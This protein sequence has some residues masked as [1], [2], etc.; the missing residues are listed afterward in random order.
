MAPVSLRSA[1][2]ISRACRPTWLSPISPSISARGT[3]AA[4][5]SMTITSTALQRTSIS[6]ISSACS[7]VSGCDTSRLS[8]STPSLRAYSM[9]SACS[10]SMNAATP[11]D[12]LRVGDHVQT[13]RRLA[14]RLRAVDLRDAPARNAADADR[15]VQVDG[16]R[17]GSPRSATR[18]PLTP[19][20]MIEPLPKA[21]SIWPM[22]TFRAF[23]LSAAI[24][25]VAICRSSGKRLCGAR[26]GRAD[27][28][29]RAWRRFPKIKRKF[30]RNAPPSTRVSTSESADRRS[31]SLQQLGDGLRQA[32]PARAIPTSSTSRCVTARSRRA[33]NCVI[34]TPARL[35][36]GQQARQA[37]AVASAKSIITMFVSGAATAKPR[38]PRGPGRPAPA[39]GGGRAAAAAKW[40]RSPCSPAAARIPACRIPPPSRR[41]TRH[42]RCMASAL[43]AS[44]EPTGAPSPLESAIVTVSTG[45]AKSRHG[46]APSRRMRSAGARRPGARPRPARAPPA[47]T[48]CSCDRGITRPP[49]PLCVFSRHTSDVCGR[50]GDGGRT[51]SARCSGR[52][53]P[54]VVGTARS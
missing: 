39:R 17:S 3:S 7:P 23:F 41:R 28:T 54:S 29:P 37:P 8:T 6:A 10:A 44:M 18:G 4:T 12:A 1:W 50:Y 32:S 52:S 26:I 16:A 22:A 40:L 30:T 31:S 15:R 36:R 5:E 48:A 51:Y 43:P 24:S 33:P 25:T 27:G 34:R 9:S 14:G 53:S 49:A 2:L 38:Q 19:I 45:A 21:F 47:A 46:H 13:Q 35:Q 20:R 11:P 42:A